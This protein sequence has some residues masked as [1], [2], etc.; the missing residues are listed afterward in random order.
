M[1][2][3]N[4]L[5][6]ANGRNGL[7][8]ANAECHVTRPAPPPHPRIGPGLAAYALLC[9]FIWAIPVHAGEGLAG[10]LAL[11]RDNDPD[12][13]AAAAARDAGVQAR[14]IGRAQLLPAISASLEVGSQHGDYTRRAT[15]LTTNYSDEPTTVAWR[16]SQPVFDLGKWAGY[17]EESSRARLAELKFVEAS[18][19]LTL[20]LSRTLFDSL[21]AADNL[22]L[23]EAQKE[24]YA[25]QRK[26]AE[27]LRAAGV[28]TLTDVEDTRARELQ[29]QA[30]AIEA[31]YG[32]QLRHRELARIVGTLP[33]GSPRPLKQFTPLAIEPDNL[34]AWLRA[35]EE[36]NPKIISARVATEITAHAADRARAGHYPSVDLIA[37]AT[38]ARDP[39]TTDSQQN[40]QSILLRLSVPIYEGGRTTAGAD[41]AAALRIQAREELEGARR[42]AM[43][44]AAEAF[45]GIGNAGAKIRALEQA[46]RAAETSLQGAKVGR[47]AGLRTHT[48][49]LN[50]QQQIFSVRRDLNKERYNHLLAGIQLKA[51]AG[52]LTDADLALIDRM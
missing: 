38:H 41:R 8:A 44:K 1:P 18:T 35:V 31:A 15:S 10:L 3:R 2:R 50:A 34:D 45:L 20:R 49:V 48:D 25:S 32:L 39:N 5:P 13:K 30:N 40:S 22:V 47:D 12:Y 42:E 11:A 6:A 51:L 23:A 37:S 28:L 21:L 17:K 52:R 33:P 14:L 29:S 4:G 43:V 26:E 36:A 46:L 16:L 24:A 27:Q 19:E 7:L 9:L